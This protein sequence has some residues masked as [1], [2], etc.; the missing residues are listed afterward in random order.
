MTRMKSL[1]LR[2][3]GLCIQGLLW[4]GSTV[5]MAQAPE[6]PAGLLCSPERYALLPVLPG[7]S[8]EKYNEIPL[9]VDL[10]PFCPLPADQLEMGS[11]VGWAVGYGALTISRAIQANLMDLGQLMQRT[12]SA[13]FIY[14]QVKIQQAD[15]RTGA[16]IEDAL[17]L[18]RDQ[19]DCLEKT[20]NYQ[21]APDC[22][23]SPTEDARREASEYRIR[24][25]AALFEQDITEK[26][27]TAVVCKAL[28][29]KTP[30]IVGLEVSPSF[31]E[32]MPGQRV[33]RPGPQEPSRGYHALVVVGY[34]NIEKQFE[35]LNSFGSRWGNNGFVRIG[36]E[37]FAQRCKYAY[38]ISLFEPDLARTQPQSAHSP[39][40][41]T[42]S[43][44]GEFVFRRPVGYLTLADGSEAPFFEEVAT[45]WDPAQQVYQLEA[46][47]QQVG[48]V[49]QLLARQIPKGQYV[50]VFSE[51]P[52][53]RVKL[54]FPKERE[55]GF[56][57]SAGA[58]IAIPSEH[59]VLQL[60]DPGWDHLC[61]LY[62]M[63]SIENIHHRLQQ[64]EHGRGDFMQRL[65]HS[66][67]DVC[68][69]HERIYTNP[70][71]MAFKA[72]PDVGKGQFVAPLVLKVMA[73]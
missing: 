47:T 56:V 50:Y 26:E 5:V 63:R 29:A 30:I 33:W 61:I 27:K 22:Q 9:R 52:N 49:F 71:S 34:D 41:P 53:G 48:D 18:L 59:T 43:L 40:P 7:Y 51:D 28:A 25:Y 21:E 20:F 58:E 65:Q 39:A 46:G 2:L 31:W 57:I 62:S 19:G 37:D 54:H 35:L 16:Y 8:G 4:W 42:Y 17:S 32:L 68:I 15:C 23:L 6:R 45:R 72:M 70:Q 12:H 66:F 3:S 60:S 69:P 73:E 67:G 13:A 14:N 55:A 24:D 11:C 36:Y 44:N 64:L 10:K 1:F 38:V